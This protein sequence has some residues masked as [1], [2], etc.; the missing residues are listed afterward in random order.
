MGLL[1]VI[2]AGALLA[3]ATTVRFAQKEQV[4]GHL[5]PTSGWSR[6][7]ANDLGVVEKCLVESG[8]EV[9]TGDVLLELSSGQG[10]ERAQTVSRKLLAEIG[11]RRNYLESHTKLIESQYEIERA[12]H[13]Q[14]REANQ[15]ELVRLE[16]EL[17][18]HQSRFET[19]RSRLD[20]SLSLQSAGL[21]SQ[22]DINTLKDEFAIRSLSVSEKRRE[23][24]EIKSNLASA[25]TRL[26]KLAVEQRREQAMVAGQIHALA[27]EE[28]RIQA[29]GA[30]RV[31]APRNGVVASVRVR[32]GDQLRPGDVLL[33]IVPDDRS[34]RARLFVRS[35]AMGFME[36]GQPV[37]VY[38]D[39]FPYQRHGAQTGRVS[40]IF[41]TT[42]QPSESAMA[43]SPGMHASE[44]VFRID[45]DFPD[46]FQLSPQQQAN[47]RPGMTLTADVVINRRTLAEWVLEP[48]E[49]AMQRL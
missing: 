40:R 38:L 30:A 49:G 36:P 5:T 18:L 27:M 46:G 10:L 12:L 15:R 20:D 21:L 42:L 33:D 24:D 45:V 43:G 4:R 32:S 14:D 25:D 34:L 41:E 37:K 9:Q 48:L 8:D 17:A 44:S 22:E 47:L 39:A 29:Q 1:A 16:R 6:V 13:V 28:S 7:M 23:L 3:F 11:Q 31:L 2:A 26:R 19:A 35:A